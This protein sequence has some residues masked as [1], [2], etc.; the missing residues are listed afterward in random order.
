MLTEKVT[1]FSNE[2]GRKGQVMV[3]QFADLAV[4]DRDYFTIPG[5]EIQDVTSLLTIV[6]GRVVHAAGAYGAMAPP[7]PPAM[8]D[9]SPVRRLG[10]YQGRRVASGA[11]TT[12][13][14]CCDSACGVHGHA[15]AHAWAAATPAGSDRGF[16][17][18]L[19]CSCWAF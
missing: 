2:E 14:R 4:L 6:G 16:W 3:G 9:W 7:L 8:P 13:A 5:D 17:G 10:G 12:M 19:G 1:W 18:A 15:H 11:F